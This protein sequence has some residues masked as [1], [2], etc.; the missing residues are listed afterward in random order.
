MA[1]WGRYAEQYHTLPKSIPQHLEGYIGLARAGKFD[2]A[3]RLFSQCLSQYVEFAPVFFERADA[4]LNQG[5]FG[6]LDE[7][8][9]TQSPCFDPDSDQSRLL[10]LMKRLANIY[11]NGALL[12][13]LRAARQ[14]KESIPSQKQWEQCSIYQVSSEVPITRRKAKVR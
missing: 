4:L 2:E 9:V 1:L 13:A 5:K 6:S 8:L 11:V 12:P 10:I 14:V 3:D 7:F